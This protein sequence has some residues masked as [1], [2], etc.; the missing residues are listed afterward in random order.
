MVIGCLQACFYEVVVIATSI[1]TGC[2][3]DSSYAVEETARAML[4]A[5]RE[6]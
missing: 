6:R 3:C 2:S 4:D 5:C 1:Q